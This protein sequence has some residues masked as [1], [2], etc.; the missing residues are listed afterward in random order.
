M[1]LGY[2][3]FYSF[4]ACRRRR[5]TDRSYRL[6][7]PDGSGNRFCHRLAD[8]RDVVLS[9]GVDTRDEHHSGVWRVAVS[10]APHPS[11]N[12]ITEGSSL[13]RCDA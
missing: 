12:K 5:T 7:H 11:K 9:G 2:S 4:R 6:V 13:P 10:Q 1:C 8:R 3:R